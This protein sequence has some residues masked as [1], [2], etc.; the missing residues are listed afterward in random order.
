M[1][2]W[3]WHCMLTATGM[4]ARWHGISSMKTASAVVLPPKP[5]GPMPRRLTAAEQLVLER[6][7]ALVGVA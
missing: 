1:C 4:L 5:C 7:E 3:A 2:R 6:R